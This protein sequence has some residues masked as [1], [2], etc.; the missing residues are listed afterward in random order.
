MHSSSNK[1][2]WIVIALAFVLLLNYCDWEHN[3]PKIIKKNITRQEQQHV[4]L[5]CAFVEQVRLW[6]SVNRGKYQ[7]PRAANVKVQNLQTLQVAKPF[8]Y[9]K[10]TKYVKI[11]SWWMEYMECLMMDTIVTLNCFYQKRKQEWL[12]KR[13]VFYI[14]IIFWNAKHKYWPWHR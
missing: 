2:S 3:Y 14:G 13:G 12:K 8:N 11:H 7:G 1:P 9:W 10:Q 5:W 6:K 4:V